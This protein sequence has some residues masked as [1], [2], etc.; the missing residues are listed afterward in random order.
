MLHR[1]L[2]AV[3]PSRRHLSV[4]L[5]GCGHDSG[6]DRG[7]HLV[8]QPGRQWYVMGND[9]EDAHEDDAACRVWGSGRVA[10]DDY[11]NDCFIHCTR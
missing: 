1:V 2:V 7:Y 4:Q 5:P 10:V 9:A 11:Y 6:C 3:L 8:W